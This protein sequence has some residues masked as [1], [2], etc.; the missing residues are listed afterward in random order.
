MNIKIKIVRVYW[1]KSVLGCL[2][3]NGCYP[4]YH[5]GENTVCINAMA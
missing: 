4:S 3:G 1:S 2:V 5:K